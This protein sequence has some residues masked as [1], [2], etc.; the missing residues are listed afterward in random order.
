MTARTEGLLETGPFSLTATAKRDLF[1]AEIGALTRHHYARCAPYRNMLDALGFEPA[2][3]HALADFPFL[4]ARIFKTLD[5]ASVPPEEIRK[6][7]TSSGTGGQPSRIPL[8]AATAGMQTKVLN[9]IV[10]NIIG[11]KRLPMLVID[12]RSTLGARRELS[13]RGAAI[14]GFS[15]FGRD[16]TYA[17]TDDM[18]LDLPAVEA[19]V[20][21]HSGEP[22][23]VF[24][25][26]FVVY[27]H[28]VTALRDKGRRLALDRAVLIHGGGWKKLAD[29]AVDNAT[30]KAMLADTAGIRRVHN[31]YGLVEQTGSIFV[32][33]ESG[34]LHCSDF[35]DVII[36]SPEFAVLGTGERGMIELIS[37]LPGSYP[38]HVLLTEDE[39][40]MTGEDDC[41]CG[42]KGKT[43][44]VHGRVAKAEIRG[45]SDTR[46]TH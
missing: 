23:L 16:H 26:T 13:A 27:Q 34:R 22:V 45:C 33:C 35:S 6:V 3:G 18:E 11:P 4:P 12:A 14:A 43:F 28:F 30:F 37:L 20:E 40:S 21:R 38:G 31:Y 7:L 44:Q 24:G 25:F 36:R 9:R 10:G 8:D 1:E 42:R 46:P 39:G 17:L 32:E 19:F 15:I 2:S 29:R 41:P 5:L